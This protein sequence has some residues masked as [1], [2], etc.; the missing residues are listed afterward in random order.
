MYASYQLYDSFYLKKKKVFLVR[1]MKWYFECHTAW[2]RKTNKLSQGL[3]PYIEA[4]N[5]TSY[6]KEITC[7]NRKRKDR[8]KKQTTCNRMQLMNLLKE[9]KQKS[10]LKVTCIYK[11]FQNAESN[12]KK[13][14]KSS[15]T[16][17]FRKLKACLKWHIKFTVGT[18][19]LMHSDILASKSR[20]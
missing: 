17:W 6:F 15:S 20:V 1:E 18:M 3:V 16:I 13:N 10:L 7:R 12:I 9:N 19:M 8:T 11:V 2:H 5:K 4:Q 14:I